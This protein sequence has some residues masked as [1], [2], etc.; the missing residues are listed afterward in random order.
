M[1]LSYEELKGWQSAIGSILGFWSLMVAA[2][3]NFHLNRRR[4]A[5]LREEEALSI[6]AALYSEIVLLR[7]EVASLARALALARINQDTQRY[8]GLTIDRH[9][10]E[11]HKLSEPQL[12]KALAAKVGLLSPDLVMAITEFHQNCQEARTW[13]P[14]LIEDDDR[15]YS[16]VSSAVL[17]PARNAVNNIVPALRKIESMVSVPTPA[18]D[19]DL[20]ETEFVIKME[21][22]AYRA[23]RQQHLA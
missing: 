6:A 11:A 22:E 16:Y 21:D 23:T 1:P 18:A 19:P 14:L 17:T 15:K 9:L 2:L 5:H 13:F 7:K 12:F 4:D 8:S 20:G 3:W 10:V